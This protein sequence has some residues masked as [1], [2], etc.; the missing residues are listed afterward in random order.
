LRAVA[1]L[2]NRHPHARQRHQV[3]LRLCDHRLRQNRGPRS[4]VEDSFGHLIL[5]EGVDSL[6]S[7]VDRFVQRST[8]DSSMMSG[9]LE[10]IA[11]SVFSAGCCSRWIR[12]TAAFAPSKTMFSVSWTLIPASFNWSKTEARTPTRS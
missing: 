11:D 8:R 6:Q 5:T 2:Q 7:T 9:L 12:A 3:A 10:R 4:E 1:D